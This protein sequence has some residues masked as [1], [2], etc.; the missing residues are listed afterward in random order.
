[1]ASPT[2]QLWADGRVT[3]EHKRLDMR[4]VVH[5]GGN[6]LLDRPGVQALA[7]RLAL[8]GAAPPVAL[9]LEVRNFLAN[10]TVDLTVTGTVESPVVQIQ[11]LRLLAEEAARF[12]IGQAAGVPVR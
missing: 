1:M 6:T 7:V 3:L 9:L 4:V 12:F 2:V 10:R 8:A 5:T 11:P